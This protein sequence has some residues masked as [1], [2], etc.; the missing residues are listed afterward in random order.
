MMDKPAPEFLWTLFKQLRRR[1]FPLG[2]DDYEA[3][4]QALRAGF[5]WSS[6]EALRDLCCALWTKSKREKE[7][8]EAL[9]DQF[10]VAVWQLSEQRVHP[11]PA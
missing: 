10:D 3:L 6:R 9:F 7:I 4:R 5:G 1:H 8:L 11:H 2:P